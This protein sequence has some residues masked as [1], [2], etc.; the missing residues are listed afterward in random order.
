MMADPNDTLWPLEPHTEAKHRILRRY[1]QAWFPI[2]S[3][4]HGRV[5]YLD[6]FAGPGEYRG[7]EPGSPLIV[8]DL[9]MQHVLPLDAKLVFIFVE[10]RPD[11]CAHLFRLVDAKRPTLPNNFSVRVIQAEFQDVLREFLDDLDERTAEI[12]PFFAFIDPFGTKGVPMSLIHRLLLRPRT[13]VF[14]NFNVRGHYRFADHQLEAYRNNNI[15]AF[16]TDEILAISQE[17]DR[18]AFVRVLYER[19]LREVA[20]FVRFFRMLDQKN[21]SIYDLFFATNNDKGH[22]EMKNA[23]WKVDNWG[24][25]RF[26]DATDPN[27]WVLFHAE[28]ERDLLPQLLARAAGR[29]GIEVRHIRTW[30]ERKTAFLAKHMKAALKL[31]EQSGQIVPR[32]IKSDGQ[33]RH[34]KTFPD[35]VIVDFV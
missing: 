1:L 17:T 34:G 28:P 29:K 2:L 19:Q 30:V 35:A 25:F 10:V 33:P 14:I 27:A 13:E 8:L 32:P 15:E 4:W 5:V 23:M 18:D 3:T 7:G 21:V 20:S 31:A 26:S 22:V 9:A 12:A 24:S 16:G 11:R 6:G